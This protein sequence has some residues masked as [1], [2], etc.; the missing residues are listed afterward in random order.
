M[1]GPLDD[2]DDD[3]ELVCKYVRYSVR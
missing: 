3:R 1:Y 2:P